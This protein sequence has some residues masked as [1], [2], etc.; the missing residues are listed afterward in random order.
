MSATTTAV[1]IE[2]THD[3]KRVI[4]SAIA[5]ITVAEVRKSLAYIRKRWDQVHTDSKSPPMYPSDQIGVRDMS[6][7]T[8]ALKFVIGHHSRRSSKTKKNT[9]EE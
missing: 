6:I 8:F 5:D 7:E 3:D 2:E 9:C 4:T 1:E